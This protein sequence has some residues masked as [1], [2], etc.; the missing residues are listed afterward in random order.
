MGA[1]VRARHNARMWRSRATMG[2]LLVILGGGARLALGGAGAGTSGPVLFAEGRLGEAIAVLERRVAAVDDAHARLELAAAYQRYGAGTLAMAQIDRARRDL[3]GEAGLAAAILHQGMFRSVEARLESAAVLAIALRSGDRRLARRARELLAQ[4]DRKSRPHAA[5]GAILPVVAEDAVARDAAGLRSAL[6]ALGEILLGN[7]H[8][9]AA[10]RAFVRATVL[11][12][13]GGSALERE[14]AWYG[15]AR[16]RA[17]AGRWSE[18]EEPARRFLASAQLIESQAPDETMATYAGAAVRHGQELLVSALA[19]Q[20]RWPEAF[21]LSDAM[22]AR[23]IGRSLGPGPAPFGLAELQALLDDD[24]V[25]V[26]LAHVGERAYAFVVTRRELRGVVFPDGRRLRELALRTPELSANPATPDGVIRRHLDELATALLVPLAPHLG[27]RRLALVPDWSYRFVPFA[28]LP[29]GGAP[30]IERFELVVL[31]SASVLAAQRAAPRRAPRRELAIIADPVFDRDDA[32]VEGAIATRAGAGELVRLPFSR[33]EALNILEVVKP[34]S[35]FVA[36]GFDATRDALLGPEVQDADVVHLATHALSDESR[37]DGSE[38]VV[39]RV[40][41]RGAAVAG[42]V[43]SMEIAGHPLAARLVVL[44]ACRTALGKVVIGD[45]PLSLAEAFMR[46]GA[47]R[48]IASLWVIEDAATAQLM[49]RLYSAMYVDQLS[50][51]AALRQAQLG[52][53]GD[54]H[55]RDIRNWAAFLHYGDWR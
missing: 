19:E 12:E 5:L 25:L 38:L 52:L 8:I 4:L 51:A 50:P 20:G 35:P 32:R 18:V 11:A 15:L 53:Q 27:G 33:V 34:S 48:V 2:F 30:L 10:E 22:R 13:A 6:V 29:L 21:L 46:A 42:V 39:S 14:R 1:G 17:R 28:A 26:E 24:T 44:S 37:L 16:S 40:D 9:E 54:P 43:S 45:G 41:R 7:R 3:P 36:L 49:R 55:F 23:R 31:P 47:P